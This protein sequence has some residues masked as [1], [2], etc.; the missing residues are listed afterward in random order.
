MKKLLSIFLIL[1]FPMV[2]NAGTVFEATTSA[3]GTLDTKEVVEITGDDTISFNESTNTLTLTDYSGYIRIENITSPITIKINGTNSFS[4]YSGE[5]GKFII[6]NSVVNFVGN[7]EEDILKFENVNYGMTVVNSEISM[8]DLSIS[9]SEIKKECISTSETGD[10]TSSISLENINGTFINDTKSAGET[11]IEADSLDI[12]NSKFNIK[13][14]K[15]G[16]KASKFNLDNNTFIMN[17]G[18]AIISNDKEENYIYESTI[19]NNKIEVSSSLFG[20]AFYNKTLFKGN[21][22]QVTG[23]LDG[24]YITNEFII[25]DSDIICN[26]LPV[27]IALTDLNETID[28][29]INHGKIIYK[30]G[31]IDFT[32][33]DI[34]LLSNYAFEPNFKIFEAPKN[35]MINDKPLEIIGGKTN[36]DEETGSYYYTF[37]VGDNYFDPDPEN[38]AVASEGKGKV[39]LGTYINYNSNGGTGVLNGNVGPKSTDIMLLEN[40]YTAPEG[41]TFKGWSLTPNGEVITKINSAEDEVTVYAIWQDSNGNIYDPS[42][43]GGKVNPETG[44]FIMV[45]IILLSSFVGFSCYLYT[46][47]RKRFI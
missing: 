17:S 22:F 24:L 31:T 46:G 6:R 43:T 19:T 13:K 38:T 35:A 3:S 44:S 11:F 39:T 33:S 40:V 36:G 12:K 27:C 47:K 41:Y 42:N 1:A 45:G 29:K 10:I 20:M 30:S 26:E 25:E 16:I 4:D 15:Y 2:V 23:V 5:T 14:A 32:Q 37:K 28:G 8:K 21:T 9:C 34:G 7:G 18:Y